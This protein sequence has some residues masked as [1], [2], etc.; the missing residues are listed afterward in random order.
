MPQRLMLK[1]L[2]THIPPLRNTLLRKDLLT[3][4]KTSYLGKYK[5]FP[6]RLLFCHT[7]SMEIY[8]N[9]RRRKR[10]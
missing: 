2:A 4:A 9:G 3:P 7:I 10:K 5:L 1:R 6:N 8:K